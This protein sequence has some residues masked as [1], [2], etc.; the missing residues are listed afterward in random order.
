MTTKEGMVRT[1]CLEHAII[2]RSSIFRM[3]ESGDDGSFVGNFNPCPM[4]PA[5]KNDRILL[6]VLF[7]D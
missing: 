3:S 5:C 1:S 7:C 4:I 6:G 2:A